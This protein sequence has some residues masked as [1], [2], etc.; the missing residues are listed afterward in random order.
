M[1]YQGC[2]GVGEGAGNLGGRDTEAFGNGV[3]NAWWEVSDGSAGV[4]QGWGAERGICEQTGA[5]LVSDRDTGEGDIEGGVVGVAIICGQ[6]LE[7]DKL[8]GVLRRVNTT[9]DNDALA[10][11][12]VI[13]VE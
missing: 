11:L 7:S 12:L 13:E 2:V 8:A 10:V 1:I 6:G 4:K 3:K 5:S 9:E